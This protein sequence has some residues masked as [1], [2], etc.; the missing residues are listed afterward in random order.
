MLADNDIQIYTD[1]VGSGFKPLPF[2]FIMVMGQLGS[3]NI[4]SRVGICLSPIF[5]RSIRSTCIAVAGH[6]LSLSLSLSLSLTLSHSID[7]NW[8][9]SHFLYI[10]GYD[11]G[12]CGLTQLI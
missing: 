1:V 5:N 7:M 11:G 9:P 10:T 6:P 3:K 12:G 2:C 8:D 4:Q